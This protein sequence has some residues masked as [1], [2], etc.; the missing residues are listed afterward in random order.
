MVVEHQARMHNLLTLV[1][2][3]ARTALRYQQ[4]L[5]EMMK[6]PADRMT[7]STRRRFRSAAEALLKYLLF[8]EEA[9]IKGEIK[10]TTTF[11]ADF[12]KPGPRDGRGRSLRDLDLKTRLFA[13]P[14]SYLI[15]SKSFD[16][17]AAPMREY[18]LRWLWEILTERDKSETFKPLVSKDRRAILEVLRET[19]PNRPEY[20]K[21]DK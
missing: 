18:V 9:P 3:E 17:I 7:D 4:V 16:E 14:C 11:A 12:V 15:Y 8:I 2:Y 13:H 1:N 19:K 6:E 10:G 5:N 20:W 21:E